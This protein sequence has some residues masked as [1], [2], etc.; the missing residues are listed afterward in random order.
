MD[1]DKI[2][3]AVE[4]GQKLETILD[5]M[6]WKG[7]KT[8]TEKT[9]LIQALKTL[10]DLAQ[11][12]IDK[13]LVAKVDER[14]IE[15]IIGALERISIP[16][17]PDIIGTNKYDAWGRQELINIINAKANIAKKAIAEYINKERK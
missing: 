16:L 2:Q 1:I 7:C 11:Q 14:E 12:V 9:E 3:N 5:S 4:I 13:E 8:H 17:T 6:F 10:L 15:K